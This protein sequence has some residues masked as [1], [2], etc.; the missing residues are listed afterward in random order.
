MEKE[1]IWAI[2]SVLIGVIS[3]F[4]RFISP[5]GL[6]VGFVGIR[7]NSN[8]RSYEVLSLIGFVLNL[9]SFAILVVQFIW[10]FT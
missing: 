2:S 6:F 8:N 5:I 7:K 3:L 9:F 4:I 1:K 10:V